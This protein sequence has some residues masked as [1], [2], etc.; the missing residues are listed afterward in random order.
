M[1]APYWHILRVQVRTS[2]MYGGYPESE[3]DAPSSKRP[4]TA[5]IH[6]QISP[7]DVTSYGL[8]E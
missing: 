5:W 7:Y 3:R 1:K 8:I 2:E 4:L 6:Q